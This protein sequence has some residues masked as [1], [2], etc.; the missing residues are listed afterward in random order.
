MYGFTRNGHK[1]TETLLD[2][3]VKNQQTLGMC[4]P[5]RSDMGWNWRPSRNSHGSLSKILAPLS[6]QSPKRFEYSILKDPK[7]DISCSQKVSRNPNIGGN[8]NL[9]QQ[10]P[11][12][13]YQPKAT[14]EWQRSD[15][16]IPPVNQFELLF[17]WWVLLP[18]VFSWVV[19]T[20]EPP[21]TQQ[22]SN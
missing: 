2:N 11:P 20:V 22:F 13:S 7:L 6:V 17:N 10:L 8:W 1:A 15:A 18:G 16:A 5:L 4:H 19:R 3:K 14:T 12:V 21:I 9:R